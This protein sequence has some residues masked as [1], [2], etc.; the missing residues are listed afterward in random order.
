MH[1]LWESFELPW[2]A[3]LWPNKIHLMRKNSVSHHKVD[4]KTRRHIIPSRLYVSR[5]I[6]ALGQLIADCQVPC[7]SLTAAGDVLWSGSQ[8]VESLSIENPPVA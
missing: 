6:A 5:A 3:H 8:A 1:V 7:G 2:L 4:C